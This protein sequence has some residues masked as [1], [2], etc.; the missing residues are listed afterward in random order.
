MKWLIITIIAFLLLGFIIFIVGK[1]LPVKHTAFQQRQFAVSK[2]LLWTSIRNFKDYPEWRSN[3][4]ALTVIN[5]TQ[6]RE[7]DDKGDAI[8]FGII[9]E[10]PE[11]RLEVKI[12]DDNLPFGGIW[13]YELTEGD[14]VVT[15]KIT[16]NGEVYNPIFRFISHFF[17]DQSATIKQYMTDLETHLK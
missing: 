16:E 7:V 13:V 8:T 2:N 15:L 3:L 1:L 9:E 4:K 12:L 17:M 10:V 11:I 14:H 5:E 6:W